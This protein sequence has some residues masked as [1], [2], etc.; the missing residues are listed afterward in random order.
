MA[1]CPGSV[2]GDPGMARGRYEGTGKPLQHAHPSCSIQQML[3]PPRPC[4]SRGNSLP[5]GATHVAVLSPLREI[6]TSSHREREGPGKSSSPYRGLAAPRPPCT[7]DREGD[8]K[9]TPARSPIIFHRELLHLARPRISR[10][11]PR[12]RD[13][14]V[15]PSGRGACCVS[16][17]EI[18]FCLSRGAAAPR[19]PRECDRGRDGQT[20][21]A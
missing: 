14:G 21:P 8:G 12:T 1:G 18:W 11:N 2:C 6:I 3:R 15:Q 20:T 17:R 7:C 13:P 4:T 9:A 5:W 16:A 19:S 10:G